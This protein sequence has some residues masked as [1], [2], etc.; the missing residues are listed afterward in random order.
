MTT[1][2]TKEHLDASTDNPKSARG[3]LATNVDN[4][5]GLRSLLQGGMAGELLTGQGAGSDPAYVAAA[6][7]GV[8]HIVSATANYSGF[9]VGTTEYQIWDWTEEIDSE[10]LFTNGG[11]LCPEAGTYLIVFTLKLTAINDPYDGGQARIQVSGINHDVLGASMEMLG[12]SFF[13]TT[14]TNSRFVVANLG[15]MI[16]FRCWGVN[17][18]AGQEAVVTGSHVSICRIGD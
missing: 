7:G 15:D 1:A 13:Y 18:I 12:G 10:G 2:M 11:Y 16:T 17:I 14:V 3:E 6:A 9:V 5:N 4:F 8:S